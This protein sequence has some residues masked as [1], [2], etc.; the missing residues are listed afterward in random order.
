MTWIPPQPV[1]AAD[2]EA[3]PRRELFSTLTRIDGWGPGAWQEIYC[4]WHL[5]CGLLA[6]NDRAGEDEEDADGSVSL[7]LILP[8]QTVLPQHLAR[9][10]AAVVA[11]ADWVLRQVSGSLGRSSAGKKGVRWRTFSPGATVRATNACWFEPASQREAPV[12]FLHLHVW[13]PLAGMCCD[14]LR[15]ARFLR[16][17]EAFARR[18]SAPGRRPDCAAHIYSVRRQR[19]LREA[20]PRYGLV[21]FL[22]RGA[23]L[24]RAADGSPL[25]ACA[26]LKV[27]R[28]HAVTVDLGSFG[29]VHGLGIRRGVTA[30]AGAPYHGKSTVLAALAAGRE[31]HP[32]G[33]G[34]EIVVSEATVLRVQA[35]DGRLIKCSD[36]SW[37]FPRLPGVSATDFSTRHAS[38]A[39]SMAAS[40]VQGMAAGCRLLLIDEDSAAG[41]FLHLDPGM[42]A[43]LGNDLAGHRT[44]VEALPAL[45]QRGVSTVLVA[46]A[47]LAS[48]S[49]ADRIL[50]MRHFQPQ[51]G[52]TQ[53]RKILRRRGLNVGAGATPIMPW[54]QRLIADDP[55]CLL[56]PRNFLSVD[57]REPER[58]VIAGVTLDLR[59]CGWTL[60]AALVR[61]ALMAA[62]WCCRL[63]EGAPMDL[64]GLERLYAE[65]ISQN[66]LRAIDPFDT[67]LMSAPPWLLVATVLERLP[68]PWMRDAA[69]GVGNHPDQ[70][71]SRYLC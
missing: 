22:G 30:V 64:A 23:L 29:R 20:L 58:P 6:V 53:A 44:L 3:Q 63:T 65:L 56:G 60:D 26:P 49:V 19:A 57:T 5:S 47:H 54:R 52:T 11:V 70:R 27:P 46:G 14:G 35:E 32:P 67:A 69:K 33:D 21:A 4:N 9:D 15:F 18:L 62:A 48:L 12:L 2:A 68:R 42:R 66:G 10:E 61:G 38:G 45:T 40:V 34:R 39:T 25:P 8:G 28:R 59:R 7:V 13:L 55:D 16:K 71:A 31:D 41:N 50:V 17:L 37:F 43:L 51:D 36:L 1:L 24:A